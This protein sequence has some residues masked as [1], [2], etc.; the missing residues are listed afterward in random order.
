MMLPFPD[1]YQPL[2]DRGV[3][4][5]QAAYDAE[6]QFYEDHPDPRVQ[7]GSLAFSRHPFM[8]VLAFVAIIAVVMWAVGA[9]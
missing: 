8:Y 6:K 1:V 2:A 7:G 9:F 5:V 3:H 4:V